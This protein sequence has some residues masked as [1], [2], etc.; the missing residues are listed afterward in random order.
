MCEEMDIPLV[1]RRTD[2]KKKVMPEEKVADE[3]LPF[4]QELKRSILQYIEKFI[5]KSI[6]VVNA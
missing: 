5:K 3:P 2:R 6:H 1:K 4:N